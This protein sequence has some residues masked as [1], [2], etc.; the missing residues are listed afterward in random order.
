MAKI[1]WAFDLSPKLDEKGLRLMVDTSAESG[2]TDGFLHCP[3]PFEA[4]IQVRSARRAETILAEFAR[5]ENGVFR[6]F[7]QA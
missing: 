6:Q 2:Y 7:E 4:N 3:K 1:L 5:A